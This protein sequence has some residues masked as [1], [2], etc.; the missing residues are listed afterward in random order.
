M[1]ARKA[2]VKSGKLVLDEPTDLPEGA[3]V[4]VALLDGDDLDDGERARLHAALAESEDDLVAGRVRPAA[5]VLADL[6]RNQ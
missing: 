4:W 2:H 5:D 1:Q 6:H 3:E